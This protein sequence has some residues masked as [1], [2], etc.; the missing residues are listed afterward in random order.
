M[1]SVIIKGFK[2]EALAIQFIQWYENQAEQEFPEWLECQDGL[3]EKEMKGAYVN[4]TATYPIKK[5][6]DG[7]FI[8]V[9]K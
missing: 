3:S 7:N 8:M 9:V 4:C 2:T 6:K 5:D 1:A